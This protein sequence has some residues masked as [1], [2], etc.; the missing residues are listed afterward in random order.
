MGKLLAFRSERGVSHFGL[1]EIF[2]YRN[3]RNFLKKLNF[4]NIFLVGTFLYIDRDDGG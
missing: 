3:V 1:S 4:R 2:S